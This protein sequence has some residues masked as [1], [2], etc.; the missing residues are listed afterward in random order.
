MG[1]IFA[2]TGFNQVVHF[3]AGDRKM[4]KTVY[5][6]IGRTAVRSICVD[7]E[8]ERV[9]YCNGRSIFTAMQDGEVEEIFTLRE[10]GSILDVEYFHPE[11]I[12]YCLAD[13]SIFAKD[14]NA[15]NSPNY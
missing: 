7:E 11:A 13:G 10:A 2:G 12:R 1:E 3:A 5:G 6:R 14:C 4:T 8:H 9:I 15:K